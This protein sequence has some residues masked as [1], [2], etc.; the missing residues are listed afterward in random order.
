MHFVYTGKSIGSERNAYQN[1]GIVVS[2]ATPFT[3]SDHVQS[4]FRS[5]ASAQ[6]QISLQH[7]RSRVHCCNLFCL[8][9]FRLL[10]SVKDMSMM[11]SVAR[12]GISDDS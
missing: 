2:R 9:L 6:T 7:R 5:Y 8:L 11:L 3:T 10:P 4:L 1:R 12:E